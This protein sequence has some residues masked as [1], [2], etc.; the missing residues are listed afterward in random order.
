MNKILGLPQ[1]L[2]SIVFLA[3]AMILIVVSSLG[4][5]LSMGSVAH[6]STGNLGLCAAACE[7]PTRRHEASVETQQRT[8][9]R[10][11][12]Y[13][14]GYDSTLTALKLV[15]PGNNRVRLI[16]KAGEHKR[17]SVYLS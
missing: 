15:E 13:A 10:Q 14:D 5:H 4:A 17:V 9:E 1:R 16:D 11:R 3:A 8:S 7:T 2:A 12:M 6:H